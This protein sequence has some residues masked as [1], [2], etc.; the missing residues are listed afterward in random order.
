MLTTWKTHWSWLT[1]RGEI[2]ENF[3]KH[4]WG[5]HLIWL[6]CNHLNEAIKQCWMSGINW[7]EAK[8]FIA[9]NSVYRYRV[10]EKPRI[11]RFDGEFLVSILVSINTS[12]ESSSFVPRFQAICS[13]SAFGSIAQT[14][15]LFKN[16]SPARTKNQRFSRKKPKNWNGTGHFQRTTEER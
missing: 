3:M 7:D 1:R 9:V 12:C 2:Y 6:H 15:P 14:I 13:D 4:F 10:F 8:R 16:S 5:V 11:Y